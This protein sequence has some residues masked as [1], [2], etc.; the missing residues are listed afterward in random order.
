[1]F[2]YL[3]IARNVGNSNP[4]ENFRPGNSAAYIWMRNGWSLLS[5]DRIVNKIQLVNSRVDMLSG[6]VWDFLQIGFRCVEPHV[7]VP[8]GSAFLEFPAQ[9]L[10]K[11]EH[12]LPKITLSST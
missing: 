2:R 6:S 3:Q 4:V 8:D 7:C 12:S 10:A 5:H 11:K 1:M 9:A